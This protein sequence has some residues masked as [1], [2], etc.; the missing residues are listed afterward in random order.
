MIVYILKSTVLLG[1]LWSLYK[2]FLENEKMHRFN[3]G[4]LLIALVVS[5]TAPLITFDIQPNTEIAG[6]N[7]DVIEQT[8]NTPARAVSRTIE[9]IL[10]A[11]PSAEITRSAPEESAGF[12]L[13][14]KQVV[15]GLYLLISALLLIRFMIGLFQIR[16]TISCGERVSYKKSQL[17]LVN[18]P[19]VPQSFLQYIF[20]NKQQYENGE[21]GDDILEHEYTHVRQL[22]SF[23][24]LLIECLKVIF[25][26]NPFLYLF[27]NSMLVNHEFLADDYVVRKLGKP[28]EYQNTLLRFSSVGS[29][30]NLSSSLNFGLTKKRFNMLSK[31]ASKT[32]ML[33]K[34]L[35]VIPVF[36]ILTMMFCADLSSSDNSTIYTNNDGLQ[37]EAVNNFPHGSYW[38]VWLDS[39]GNPFSG[40]QTWLYK[41]NDR[42]ARIEHYENGNQIHVEIFSDNGDLTYVGESEFFENNDIRHL[43]HYRKYD[44]L[45]RYL[46]FEAKWEQNLYTVKEYF[47]NGQLKSEY[48]FNTE[49]NKYDG[50]AFLYDQEGN[51]LSQNRYEDGELVEKIK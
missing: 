2:L 23:D 32:R 12:S 3:R 21:L 48:S 44:S 9:P 14:L 29:A 4:Y 6:I 36:S 22:H 31:K 51:L 7:I 43:K 47:Q 10:S 28:N 5:F 46:D 15:I 41:A 33:P 20:L 40:K 19:I 50:L 42:I 26:F 39:N 1:L 11:P 37:A 34:A 16:K 27:K 17:V 49:I 45:E 35:F 24:V 30:T 25:W 13:S 18:Q 8:V 38:T